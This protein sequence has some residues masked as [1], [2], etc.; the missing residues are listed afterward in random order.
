MSG[1]AAPSNLKTVWSRTRKGARNPDSSRPLVVV[2]V[3]AGVLA[4]ALLGGCGSSTNSVVTAPVVGAA[5][6][7]SL[8]GFK[9]SGPVIAGRPT[10][11]SFT[12]QLPDGKP[13]TRYRTGPGPHTGVHMIIVRNDLAYIIH[14]HPPIGPN[15]ALTQTVRFPTPGPYRVLVDIYPNVPGLAP[16][17][18]LHQT[19]NVA[20]P[21]HPRP[22]PPFKSNLVVD[23]YHIDMQRHP[24]LHAIQAQFLHVSGDQPERPQRDLR[25]VVRRAGPRD[26]LPKRLA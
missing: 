22:L 6:T 7:F 25:S 18:Q 9:P 8:A 2:R 26:L 5:R 15:G 17:F 4:A 24:T 19:V 1:R 23:G 10:T 21:Y 11:V 16:N 13:L 20:G 14:D 3:L 12:V